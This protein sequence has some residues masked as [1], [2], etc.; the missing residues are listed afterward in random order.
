MRKHLFG[1][2]AGLGLRPF[3]CCCRAAERSISS[4]LASIKTR[5]RLVSLFW[6]PQPVLHASAA[7]NGFKTKF[8]RNIPSSTSTFMPSGMRCIRETVQR[9][10]LR[11]ARPCRMPE[12][13]IIG[14]RRKKP[15]AGSRRMSHPITTSPSCGTLT[16][17]MTRTPNGEKRRSR[18]CPMEGHSSKHGK[19]Y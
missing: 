2:P 4:R 19:N 12:W 5:E 16:T 11:L 3:R 7:L 10:S 13:S 17:C 18:L 15:A 9:R 14:T 1:L 8:W 6:S